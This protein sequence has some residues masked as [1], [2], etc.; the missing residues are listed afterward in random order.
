MLELLKLLGA[1]YFKQQDNIR[2]CIFKDVVHMNYV[3]F[4]VVF[5]FF[6]KKD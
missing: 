6:Q 2:T 1:V 5:Y 3:T 4:N